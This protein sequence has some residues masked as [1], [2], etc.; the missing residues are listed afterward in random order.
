MALT[1]VQLKPNVFLSVEDAKDWCKIPTTNTDAQLTNRIARLLNMATDQ[2]EKYIDGPVKIREIV[3]FKD[4]D[5]SNVLVPDH[6]PVRE[7]VDLRLDF[8]RGFSDATIITSENYVLRGYSDFD[9]RIRGEDIVL[10]DDN[11]VSLVGRI[12]TGSTVGAV[13]LKYKAGWGNDQNDI[14]ADLVQAVLIAVDYFYRARDNSDIGISSK[15][16]NNQGYSRSA[17]LPKEVTEILDQYKDFTL[18]RNNVPQRNT[19]TD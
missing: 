7:V 5:S 6:Y 18:G 9:G 11:N 8:N 16:N 19:F 14:P 2:V 3:E 17:G 10:R 13:R 12:F 1:E 4:G 15:N